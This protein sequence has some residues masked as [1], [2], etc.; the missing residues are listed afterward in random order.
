MEKQGKAEYWKSYEKQGKAM[1]SNV[2]EMCRT[3]TQGIGKV[4]WREVMQSD[5]KQRF[6]V[7]GEN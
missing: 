6:I 1:K 7:K 4:E 5:A 3:S 2:T